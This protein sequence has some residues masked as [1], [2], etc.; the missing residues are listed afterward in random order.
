MNQSKKELTESNTT[1]SN[2]STDNQSEYLTTKF[3]LFKN[4]SEERKRILRESLYRALLVKDIKF[5]DDLYYDGKE[6]FHYHNDSSLEPGIQKV[7]E[8][9]HK[10]YNKF[11][12][13]TRVGN[14][15][16]LEIVDDDNQGF[17]VKAT[18]DIPILTLLCEY[19]GEV[20][21]ARKKLFDSNDSIMDLIRTPYSSTSLVIAPEKRGNI[22][23]FFSGINNNN[24]DKKKQNVSSIR[25]DIGGSVHVL[26]YSSRKIK[27]NEVLYYDYNAGGFSGYPTEHFV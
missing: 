24:S 23:R 2:K 15:P 1:K 22:A 20:H 18:D 7:S 11:K 12:E 25:L 27:K 26:L 8:Y 13:R 16:A 6:T 3:K 9:N 10:I 14:Y 4:T 17:I 5:D 21:F 19:S